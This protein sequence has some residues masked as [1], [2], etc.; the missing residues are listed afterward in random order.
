MV[1]YATR[2]TAHV[3][4]AA[5]LVVVLGLALRVPAIVGWGGAILVAVAAARAWT[6]LAVVRVRLAG[7]EMVWQTASRV[8]EVVR[9]GELRVRAVLRNRDT[10]PVRFSGARAVASGELAATVSPREGTIPASG[11]VCIEVTVV[12]PRVGRYGVHGITLDLAGP[13]GLFEVPLGFAST[14]GVEVLPKASAGLLGS[15]RGGRARRSAPSRRCRNAPGD[16]TELYQLREHVAGDPFKRIAWRASARRGQLM[17]KEVEREE[18]D[19]VWLVLD[20]AVDLWAGA[21]GGAPLDRGIDELANLAERHLSAGDRVGLMVAAAGPQRVLSAETGAAH[22]MR[23]QAALAFGASTQSADRSDLSE[24]EA[25]HLVLEHLRFLDGR[26]VRIRSRQLDLVALAAESQRK[27]APF[28][29][30]APWAPTRRERILRRYMACFG[31]SSPPRVPQ[32]H[33]AAD[34]S[35]AGCLDRLS[36]DK[37]RPS[38]VYVWG[39]VPDT[40]PP[41]LV[42]AVRKLRR[43][44]AIVRWLPAAE[45]RAIVPAD[46]SSARIA[47]FAVGERARLSRERGERTLRAAGVLLMRP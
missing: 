45:D 13:Q 36:A 8:H 6:L 18:R 15:A 38:I 17:V 43:I 5:S 28:R 14:L 2:P 39:R 4:L 25:G 3:A 12:A 41:I 23:V 42:T 10:A 30:P 44:G 16:G 27:S 7:L 47:A 35:L 34:R 37:P 26:N 29:L 19:V 33:D 40:T 24:E 22:A 20:A 21:V 1:V 11:E 9:T 46:G 32:D 31:L